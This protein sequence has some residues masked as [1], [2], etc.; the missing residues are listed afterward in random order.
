[1]IQFD[2]RREREQRASLCF[3]DGLLDL[4][5]G[6]GL[7]ALGFLMMLGLGAI[8][9]VYLAMLIPI[10]NLLPRMHHLD[11]LPDPE[12]EL[13]VRRVRAVVSISMGMLIALGVLAFFSSRM[14]PAPVPQWL[15]EHAIIIFGL[16]LAALF[17][18]LGWGTATPR[19]RVYAIV[20]AVAL[21]VG[22]WFNMSP[23]WFF[24]C[25]G[26]LIAAW[27]TAVLV[28]FIHTYPRMNG[29]IDGAHARRYRLASG[30]MEE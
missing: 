10:V 24:V 20:T 30:R 6:I 4:G 17:M 9:G 26:A 23:G 28:H 2:D 29:G 7:L 18:L 13:R 25:I 11:F 14:I 21:V 22:Y 12:A 16:M 27:G 19:L 3:A 5:I 1:M 8:A 15:W